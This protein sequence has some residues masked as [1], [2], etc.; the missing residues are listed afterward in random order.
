ME[1]PAPTDSSET[2]IPASIAQ[3]TSLK[4]RWKDS[5]NQRTR[6]PLVRLCLLEMGV[7]GNLYPSYIKKYGC[8]IKTQRSE[9][10]LVPTF[11]LRAIGNQWTQRNQYLTSLMVKPPNLSSGH[12]WNYIHTI[13]TKQTQQVVFTCLLY[14]YVLVIIKR[15]H[16]ETGGI[17]G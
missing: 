11:R 4:R 6:I 14:K 16:F 12:A 8:L 17:E 9:I 2:Q 7:E 10:L 13:H 3:G 15:Y 1:S 5:K